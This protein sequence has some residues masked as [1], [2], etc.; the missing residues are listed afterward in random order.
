MIDSYDYEIREALHRKWLRSYHSSNSDA[1]VINELG[2]LH[3]SNRIDVAVIN[4]CIHGYEIKSSKDTL[5]RL[6]GQLKV[7][8]MTLQKITFVVA[9]NHIDE[10]MTSV[11][12]WSGIIV[13][14]K[15]KN[16]GISFKTLRRARTN[17]NFDM[18][19][20][21]H[22]LW[23]DEAQSILKSK[24]LSTKDVNVN[25]KALY[26]LICHHL[27]TKEIVSLIK[28]AFIN[29][30]KWRVAELQTKYDD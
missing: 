16:G 27:E 2:L 30:E 14:N 18:F 5:K 25:R 13:A 10:L 21:S 23:R 12:P 3:G 26:N 4:N 6:N 19:S 1:L 17:P 22:L 11:P 28:Q 9:P 15:G 7:Y 24:G 20:V 8:A 29:R